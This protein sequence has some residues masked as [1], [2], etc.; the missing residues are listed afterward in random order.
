[1]IQTAVGSRHKAE[2]NRRCASGECLLPA[3]RRR[4]ALRKKIYFNGGAG[5]AEE[6]RY[7]DVAATPRRRRRNAPATRKVATSYRIPLKHFFDD[8]PNA[9]KAVFTCDAAAVISH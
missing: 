3:G 7:R 9:T 4:G 5:T 2:N 1:M 6:Q 8:D